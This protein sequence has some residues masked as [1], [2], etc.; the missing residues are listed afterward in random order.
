[1]S[2]GLEGLRLG[3]FL[4]SGSFFLSHFAHV[5]SYANQLGAD[6]TVVAPEDDSS[7]AIR[8]AG[9][10]LVHI[11]LPRLSRDPIDGAR[12]VYTLERIYRRERLQLVHHITAKA[13]ICGSIAARLAGDLAT[14]NSITGLGYAFALQSRAQLLRLGLSLAYR[15]ALKVSRGDLIFENHDDFALFRSL[16]VTG[17]ETAVIVPGTGVDCE[18][19]TPAPRPPGV[20][21]FA[22]I[23]RMVR[24]KGFLEFLKAAS[25]IRDREAPVRL[26]AIGGVDPGNPTSLGE[27][28]L[29]DQ[30]AE[31]GVEHL[32]FRS[33]IAAELAL[34]H[35]IVLPSWRE[36]FPRVLQEAAASGLPAITTDVP[37]CRE[38]IID[39]E[40]G[41]LVPPRDHYALAGAIF[42]LAQSQAV[43]ERMGCAARELALRSFNADTIVPEIV[44]CYRRALSRR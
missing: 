38:A 39:G 11:R 24:D 37:G 12:T 25:L 23:G 36:G 29:A 6:V 8:D 13:V 14:V 16:G 26:I 32:G 21:A 41:I 33:D 30:C 43:R 7:V 17:V 9:F 40:T 5:A 4:N 2:S 20:P 10:R 22:F 18:R 19:F 15:I 44:R 28:D 34:I 1:V 31:A 35:G 42:E 3:Y 27:R